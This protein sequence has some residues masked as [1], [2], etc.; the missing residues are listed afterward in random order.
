VD[1]PKDELGLGEQEGGIPPQEINILA[2]DYQVSIEP[3]SDS[4]ILANTLPPDVK[5]LEAK[6]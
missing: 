4:S 2:D 3:P 6:L 1:S 5:K